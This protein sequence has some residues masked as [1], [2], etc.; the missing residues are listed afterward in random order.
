[1]NAF[2]YDKHRWIQKWF[3]KKKQKGETEAYN[4][5]DTPPF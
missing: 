1:M 2:F 4:K 3:L 5:A